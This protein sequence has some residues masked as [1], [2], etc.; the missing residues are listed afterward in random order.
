[1]R[2]TE[3]KG[4]AIKTISND[5]IEGYLINSDGIYV[6]VFET[7]A[8]AKRVRDT[9]GHAITTMQSASVVL[10]REQ[11]APWLRTSA[12]EYFERYPKSRGYERPE[13]R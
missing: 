2:M 13:I 9:L 1:M 10:F 7:F 12:V 8:D 5:G 4:Y 6:L 11:H 3:E